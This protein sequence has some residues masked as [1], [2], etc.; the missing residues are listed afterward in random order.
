MG[1]ASEVV[2]IVENVAPR[3]DELG[4]RPDVRHDRLARQAQVRLRIALAQ[5]RGL[6]ERHLGRDVSGERVVRGGL[7]GDEVEVLAT[8][9]RAP[10]RRSR[11][12]RAARRRA[13][14]PPQRPRANPRERV[15]ERVGDLVQVPR[16]E[17]P[18]DPARVD[19][20]AEDRRARHRRGE[21]LRAAHPAEPGGEDRPPGQVRRSEVLLAGRRE[22]LVRALQDPLRADVDPA[23][24]GHLAEHRQALG[25]EPPE[26]V[27]GR[28]ARHEQRVRDEDARRRTQPSGRPRP[29]CRSGRAASRPPRSR[30]SVRTM[31]FSAS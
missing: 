27:P 5:R 15:V 2:A 30:R 9:R 28:P 23:A 3:S 6:L 11:H 26:L 16:L 10:G 19:L 29:A 24:G 22:R 20:D 13:P 31:S 12:S 1:L 14:V 4:H 18:L 17:P 21:R 7:V 8:R 25:L